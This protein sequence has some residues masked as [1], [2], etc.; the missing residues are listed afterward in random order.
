MQ[1]KFIFLVLTGLL[2]L[3]LA[4][5]G[6]SGGTP[7]EEDSSAQTEQPAEETTGE[8]DA[9]QAPEDGADTE[10]PQYTDNFSVDTEAVTAFAEQIQAAVAE[11]DLE[12]LADLASYPLYIGFSDGGQSVESREDLIALGA[13]QIFTEELLSEIA[14]ADP[15]G[16]APSKAGFALST[17]GRPN[18]VFSVVDGRLAIV[19]MNY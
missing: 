4:G 1:K 2:C 12:A 9:G 19:G 13:D 15:A 7:P 3:S 16:L 17:S 5:C 11:K 8:E 18:V 10:A 14:G 6:Q